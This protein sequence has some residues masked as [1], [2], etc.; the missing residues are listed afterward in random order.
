[1]IRDYIRAEAHQGEPLSPI[2]GL[3]VKND[4]YQAILDNILQHET[5]DKRI[6]NA[7]N[8][9]PCDVSNKR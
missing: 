4:G 5:T 7:G 2:F 1:M 8:R 6:T 9:Y 3:G